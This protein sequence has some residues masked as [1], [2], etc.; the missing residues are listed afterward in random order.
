MIGA[1]VHDPSVW[2]GR[3]LQAGFDDLEVFGL[4]HLYSA[5]LR[6][7]LFPAI[8]E[9]RT[10]PISFTSRPWKAIWVTRSR[11]RRRDRFS[12][13]SIQLADLGRYPS[14]LVDYSLVNYAAAG[15][16]RVS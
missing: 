16:M 12:I 10:H 3:A 7:R 5:L 15:V 13:S 4:A 1:A 11:M 6:E 2:T 14:V 8:M 9:V